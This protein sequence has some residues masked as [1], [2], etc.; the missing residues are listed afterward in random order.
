MQTEAGVPLVPSG[1]VAPEE[2]SRSH[3]KGMEQ[4]AH[5]ARLT[6]FA[7]VPLALLSQQTWTAVANTGGIDDP[8]TPIV[9]ATTL[10]RDQHVACRTPEGSV[11]LKGKVRAS[12]AVRFPGRC[13]GG[14]GIPRSRSRE[15]Q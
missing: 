1:P 6:R 11:W 7:A 12:E 10:M 5:L 13:G 8:E 9:F 4:D 15:S 3:R 14:W 2:R